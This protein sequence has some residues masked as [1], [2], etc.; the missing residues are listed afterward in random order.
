MLNK[1]TEKMRVRSCGMK[2]TC[3]KIY[4]SENIYVYDL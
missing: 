3:T 1:R 2:I 4:Y